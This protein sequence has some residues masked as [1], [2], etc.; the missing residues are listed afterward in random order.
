MEAPG[1]EGPRPHLYPFSACWRLGKPGAW[2]V[3][4]RGRSRR[5]LGLQALI[6]SVN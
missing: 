6:K 2:R 4:D 5:G 1:L 3:G